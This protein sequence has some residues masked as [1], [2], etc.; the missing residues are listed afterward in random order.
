MAEPAY[1]YLDSI[2][3]PILL[4]VRV[5]DVNR[6]IGD[7]KGTSYDF[8]ERAE[9]TPYI[10]FNVEQF[11]DDNP[12]FLASGF[13]SFEQAIIRGAKVRLQDLPGYGALAYEIDTRDPIHHITVNANVTII[14][15]TDAA[16]LTAPPDVDTWPPST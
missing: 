12:S 5:H 11:A 10:I 8:A 7:I 16:L 13:T 15:R 2:A 14:G 6:L 3:E 4:T 1:L 9:N